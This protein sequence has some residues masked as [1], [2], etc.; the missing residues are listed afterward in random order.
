MKFFKKSPKT[1]LTQAKIDALV[2]R[3]KAKKPDGFK[4]FIYAVVACFFVGYFGISPAI[5]LFMP[6]DMAELDRLRAEMKSI[7]D[8][9]TAEQALGDYTLRIMMMTTASTKL[10]DAKKQV[11]AREIVRVANDTFDTLDH[12][13]AFVGLLAIESAFQ[14]HAVSPTGPRGLGQVGHGA[15]KEGLSVCGI[16]KFDDSDVF[17]TTLNLTASACYFRTILEA[18]GG[19]I[20][21]SLVFYNQGP[22]S[23]SGKKYAKTGQLD[24]IEALKYVARFSFLKQKAADLQPKTTGK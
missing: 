19:D 20:I 15:L 7:K 24:N 8:R 2:A 6:A 22:S 9:E 5:K 23:E 4:R 16:T 3:I 12:K 14:R 21:A 10:S 17:D 11:L 18:N 13:H 1:E